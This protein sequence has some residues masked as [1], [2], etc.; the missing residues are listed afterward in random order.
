MDTLAVWMRLS[1]VKSLDQIIQRKLMI[2]AELESCMLPGSMRFDGDKVQA[3][4]RDKLSELAI[5]LAD[6]DADLERLMERKAEAI[7]DTADMIELL[8]DETEKLVLAGFFIA[9]MTARRIGEQIHYSPRR[10]NY[11]RS[12]AMK[13]LVDKLGEN[14]TA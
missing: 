12:T 13:K 8:D 7:K 6:L 4:P 3:T 10:V 11:F 5:Q 9:R 2:K 14:C 1:R